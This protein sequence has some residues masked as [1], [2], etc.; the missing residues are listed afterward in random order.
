M[1]EYSIDFLYCVNCRS[2][3]ELEVFSKSSEIE[4]GILHCK[5]CKSLFPI[6]EKIPVLWTTFDDYL[7]NRRK[8]GGKL[9]SSASHKMKNFIKKSLTLQAKNLEDR[10]DLEDRWAK[11]YQTNCRSRFYSKIKNEL[12]HLPHSKFSLE[13]GCSIG[14]IS[15][16]LSNSNDISFGID[17]SFSAIKIAQKNPKRNLDYFVADLFS[18]IFGKQKFN[19]I[20]ALNLLELVEPLD[21]LKYASSQIDKGTLVIS[22]PYDYDRGKNSVKIPL[23]ENSLRQ[24]LKIHGFKIQSRTSGPSKISW[25]LKLHSR[26]T[27]NYKVDLVIANK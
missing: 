12:E 5:T 22:D 19:L 21:F 18:P 25:N 14:I 27:L 6:I 3:L 15:R 11:I 9:F 26:A 10:T 20:V 4:E 13:Y 8:L 1:K 23:D 2:K 7:S 24:N 16:I 17:R